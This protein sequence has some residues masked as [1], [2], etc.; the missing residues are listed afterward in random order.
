MYAWEFEKN[1]REVNVR[2]EGQLVFNGA[3]A[4]LNAALKG[5]GP[6][7]LSDGRVQSYLANGQ[8]VRV[9]SDWCPAFCGYHLYYPT[10][11]QPSPAFSLLVD[12]LRY[13]RLAGRRERSCIWSASLAI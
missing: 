7:Y 12:A 13:K 5:F 10:R 11:R 1:G 8:L 9:L 3:G 4:L 6:A 2:V